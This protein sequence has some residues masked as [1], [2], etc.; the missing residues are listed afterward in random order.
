[1]TQGPREMFEVALIWS[2]NR[3]YFAT[4]IGVFGMPGI[5]GT[6]LVAGTIVASIAVH[7]YFERPTMRL[8][9]QYRRGTR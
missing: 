9:S 1:M 8:A 7:Q 2:V 4:K 6:Q 5:V 3:R